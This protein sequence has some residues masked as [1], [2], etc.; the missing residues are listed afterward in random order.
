M[1]IHTNFLTMISKNLFCYFGKVFIHMNTW[2]RGKNS[3]K[4]N[5]L[6]KEDFYSNLNM[7]DITAANKMHA[8]GVCKDSEIKKL[9]AYHDMCVQSN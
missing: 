9:T 4:H 1:L 6:K 8:K 7:E 5:Y 2:I 3:M